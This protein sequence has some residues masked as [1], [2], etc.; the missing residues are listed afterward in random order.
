MS[1]NLEAL[2]TAPPFCLE[3]VRESLRLEIA[4]VPFKTAQMLGLP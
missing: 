1:G 2:L 3:E 4:S